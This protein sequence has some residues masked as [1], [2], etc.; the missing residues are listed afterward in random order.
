MSRKSAT[1]AKFSPSAGTQMAQLLEVQTENTALKEMTLELRESIADVQL[2][3][4][5][6]GWSPLGG[7]YGDMRELPLSTIRDQTRVTRALAVINPLIKRGI[8][9]RIAYIWGNGI[10]L[11]GLDETFAKHAGNKKY[12]LSEKAQMEMESCLA[13]D[14]N[15]FLLVTK[16]SAKTQVDRLTRVPLWQITGTVSDPDNPEDVWFYRRE[17]A[18]TVTNVATEQETTSTNIEYFPAIDYDTANGTPSQFKGKRVN[19]GSRIAAHSVNKQT[20]WKW[21]VPDILP[22]MFWAKAHKEFLESQAT[23]VKAYS[24]F[25]WKVAAPTAANARA[26]STKVG[27]APS[28]DPMTG[29]PQGVGATAV[30]GQG[31]T[32]SSVGRTG[33]SV[34]FEAGLPLA[35]YV[36]AGLSVPLT[37]LTADAGN[38]NRSSAETLSGSNE[39]VMKARQAE[40]KMFYEAIFAYL[41]MEVK[42]SF[43]K[44]EEE[45]VYRQIQSLVSL[46]TLN[47]F[48]DKEM[49]ALIIHALDIQ[50]MDPEKVPTKEELGNLI[51]QATMAAEQAKAAA[52]AAAK[53][54]QLAPGAP[55][56]PGAKAPKVPGVKKAASTAKSY[57][58]NSYRKDASTAARTGA[59]G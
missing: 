57:G 10:K 50:D 16:K 39:K 52:D 59:K 17:W 34:D 26:A 22:V 18:T 49:R 56:V 23:L 44:I 2:A 54:P 36:A 41:G 45:A 27:T 58:D 33:G 3:L 32:I 20:G 42:V 40:H 11:D 1:K 53:A 6:I 35:G 8:A 46:L 24:R 47:V 12:L 48:S 51:L 38:A 25:A 55:A 4:D 29:Q 13:T 5:N 21:G 28:I 31:T 43:P 19:W 30:T 14:G 9:V 7:E 15:F 37:E